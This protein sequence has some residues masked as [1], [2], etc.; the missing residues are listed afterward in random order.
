MTDER[1]LPNTPERVVVNTGEEGEVQATI[2]SFFDNILAFLGYDQKAAASFTRIEYLPLAHHGPF[3]Y[4]TD[5]YVVRLVVQD[6]LAAM[7][8]SRR[9]VSNF[10]EFSF[11]HFL[12]QSTVD[13]TRWEPRL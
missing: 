9:N 10:V 2:D 8:M 4:L 11:A 1:F 5:D 6:V 13:R 3:A 12:C 7:V